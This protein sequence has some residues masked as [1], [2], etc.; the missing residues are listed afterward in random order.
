MYSCQF[1]I[2]CT[3]LQHNRCR[4][5][6]KAKREKKIWPGIHPCRHWDSNPGDF[7]H[8]ETVTVKVL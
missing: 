2:P 5:T 4:D 8:E 1:T 3:D 6:E 7:R